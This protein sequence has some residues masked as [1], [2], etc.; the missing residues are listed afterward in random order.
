MTGDVKGRLVSSK[1]LLAFTGPHGV[2]YMNMELFI[3]TAVRF[4]NLYIQTVYR[5]VLSGVIKWIQLLH[6]RV[7]REHQALLNTVINLSFL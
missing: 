2:L 6:C 5:E 3:G 1:F 7:Q 4:S